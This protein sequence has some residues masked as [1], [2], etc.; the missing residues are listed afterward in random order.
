MTT[1]HGLKRTKE[2]TGYNE[3][4][5]MCFINNAIE[6]GKSVDNLAGAE[7]DYLMNKETGGCR[8]LLYNSYCFIVSEDNRCITMFA[9]RNK[10]RLYNGKVRIRDPRKYMRMTP[11]NIKK[12]DDS[13]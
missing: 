13:V 9:A 7:K 1:R 8:A 12:M 6:R 4:K 11:G 10:K 5:A 2:R 3:R